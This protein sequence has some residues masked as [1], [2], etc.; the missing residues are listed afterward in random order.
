LLDGLAEKDGVRLG[1]GIMRGDKG[2]A[3]G[4]ADRDPVRPLRLVGR[5]TAEGPFFRSRDDLKAAKE[6]FEP[7]WMTRLQVSLRKECVERKRSVARS[8][9][10]DQP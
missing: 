1:L 9:H 4:A 10:G 2:I 6:P 7:T 3:K 5:D 8:L